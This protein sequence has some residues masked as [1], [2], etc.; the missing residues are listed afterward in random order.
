MFILTMQEL[1][2][3][4]TGRSR[5]QYLGTRAKPA[6]EP[7]CGLIS[8]AC[9]INDSSLTPSLQR[10]KTQHNSD[11]QGERDGRKQHVCPRFRLRNSPVP[12]S[13]GAFGVPLPG[14]LGRAMEEVI[15]FAGS[16]R[17]AAFLTVRKSE[18][19]QWS[20]A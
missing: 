18:A 13:P 9:M 17:R 2:R 8:A 11:V 12:H 19:A 14:N 3:V 7:K 4:V 10:K 20:C 1:Y 6:D 15:S 16:Q 5:Y